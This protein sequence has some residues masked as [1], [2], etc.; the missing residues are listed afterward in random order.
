MA[1]RETMRAVVH[2]LGQPLE[3]VNAIFDRMR[4]NRLDGRVVLDLAA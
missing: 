3:E 2:E 1:G 4:P